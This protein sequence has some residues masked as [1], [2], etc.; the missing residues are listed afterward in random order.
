MKQA[1][2]MRVIWSF[3]CFLIVQISY[4]ASEI[5]LG[6]ADLTQAALLNSDKLKS[7]NQ[8]ADGIDFKRKAIRSYALPQFNIEGNYKYTTDLPTMTI[9]LGL[10]EREIQTG[11]HNAY[12]MG[13][14]ANYLVTDFGANSLQQDSMAKIK[15][16]K[17]R[18]K[19]TLGQSLRLEVKTTFFKVM[20]NI[21][22]M[23]L[24]LDSW[25]LSQAQHTEISKHFKAG[26]ASQF[27]YLQSRKEA[28][29]YK[30][31]FIEAQN[32]L[33]SDLG[34]LMRLSGK[35]TTHD[36]IILPIEKKMISLLPDDLE[37]P[38]TII[39]IDEHSFKKINVDTILADAWSIDNPALQRLNSLREGHTL[40]KRS[41]TRAFLPKISIYAKSGYEYPN[42]SKS[43]FHRQNIVG[44]NLTMPLWDGGLIMS[45]RG[46]KEAAILEVSSEEMNL[47]KDLHFDLNNTLNNLKDLQ[48]E[49]SVIGIGVNDVDQMSKLVYQSYRGGKSTITD[50][51]ATNLKTLDW[52]VRLANI[53]TQILMQIAILEYLSS[54]T[55]L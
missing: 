36:P 16:A 43:E 2:T 34:H 48:R 8:Q 50:V 9:P 20:L 38:Q 24:V 42:G 23:R 5:H 54:R 10:T 21:E 49:H 7:V 53:Q 31:R 4:G 39:S 13:V 3:T 17:D 35:D 12:F 55:I 37:R 47:K 33:S 44:V 22:K 40:A 41:V 30:S 27:D 25:R 1:R 11:K 15:M 46:E 14:S 28:L 32:N 45:N 29:D 26:K 18:E 19:Q 6:L 51:L 52:K